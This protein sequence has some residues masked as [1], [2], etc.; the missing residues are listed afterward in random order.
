MNPRN[1]HRALSRP[2]QLFA[3]LDSFF[4]PLNTWSL[5]LDRLGWGATPG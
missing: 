3:D 1:R 2:A 4:R 5:L